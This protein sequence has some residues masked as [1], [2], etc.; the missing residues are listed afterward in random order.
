MS[1]AS[2][3]LNIEFL[4]LANEQRGC[5]VEADGYLPMDEGEIKEQIS[6]LSVDI[7]EKILRVELSDAV[8]Q[9]ALNDDI[10]KDLKLN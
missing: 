9:K 7:A 3:S 1:D 5:P 6:K 8:K 4:W 2:R 10:L